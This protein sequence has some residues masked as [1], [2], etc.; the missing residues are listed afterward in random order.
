MRCITETVN[1]T[2]IT[3]NNARIQAVH[4]RPVC[5]V[6]VPCTTPAARGRRTL[7]SPVGPA[8]SLAAACCFVSPWQRDGMLGFLDN[9]SDYG[10]SQAASRTCQSEK[11]TQKYILQVSNQQLNGERFEMW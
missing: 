7:Y 6:C 10:T 11:E 2:C 8:A 3:H 9:C 5:S 4:A 1:W